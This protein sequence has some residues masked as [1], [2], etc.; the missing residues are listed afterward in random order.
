[1]ADSFQSSTDHS[2][3]PQPRADE[4]A[5]RDRGRARLRP[6][7]MVGARLERVS[8]RLLPGPRR[9]ADGRL[10]DRPRH[11]RR[12][13]EAGGDIA[14]Y[15]FC[16]FTLAIASASDAYESNTVFS[17]MI[18]KTSFSFWVR[19]QSLSWPSRLVAVMWPEASAATPDES[20][21]GT[22]AMLRMTVCAPPSN[23]RRIA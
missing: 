3:R 20:M 15:V 6:L 5:G 17:R 4:T 8:H 10:V 12:A 7:R 11:R 22:S 18:R 19:L 2:K 14:P 1:M 16:A 21:P 23:A 9:E 13:D